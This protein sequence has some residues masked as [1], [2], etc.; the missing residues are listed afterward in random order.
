[1]NAWLP[2]DTRS[3]YNDNEQSFNSRSLFM[4]RM[5][6]P[7]AKD[8]R[9]SEDRREWFKKL[10]WLK[11]AV[12]PNRWVIPNQSPNTALYAKLLSRLM[13][14]MAGGVMEN[15]GLC[16]DRFGNPYIPGSAIKGCARR[17]AVYRLQQS[18]T[19]EE[20]I[21]ILTSV[22]LIFGWAENDWAP[23]RSKKTARAH[24]DFW[25]AMAE[26]ELDAD[27]KRNEN[28][29]FVRT[30]VQKLI[31]AKIFTF[32]QT[33][34]FPSTF[35]GWIGFLHAKPIKLI[36]ETLPFGDLE[37]DVLTSHHSDYYKNPKNKQIAYDDENPIPVIF[38]AVS[39]GHVFEF[40]ILPTRKAGET[41]LGLAKQWLSEGLS[42][43]GVGAKTNVGYGWFDSSEE[44]D[45][46]IRT[47]ILEE[48]EIEIQQK[49]AEEKRREDKEK[50]KRQQE[51]KKLEIE[52]L[53]L[54][55]PEERADDKLNLMD[56]ASILNLC[57]NFKKE[58]DDETKKALIRAL[59]KEEVE[60]GSKRAIWE[61]IK[62]NKKFNS[63]EN[64]IREY[65]YKMTPGKQ[66]KMP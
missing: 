60:S 49:K 29:E 58:N 17:N 43:F 44:L 63:A 50:E 1:M 6:L 40:N 35:G 32:Q 7:D 51:L 41:Y 62:K 22:A 48:E 55:S 37:L 26:G 20:K 28:W 65:S 13:V 23:D 4:D 31:Q 18:T 5:P 64:L 61:E 9:D 19:L 34:K 16:I 66:G 8:R 42:V 14:N 10:L 59:K 54:M 46:F 15:A 27:C 57:R 45:S 3:L 21:E 2:N 12:S 36:S 56:R 52:R 47:K 24:S 30:R 11:P 39:A 38:P 53:S 33:D 25:W